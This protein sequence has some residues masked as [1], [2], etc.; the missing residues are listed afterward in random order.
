MSRGSKAKA[1]QRHARRRARERFGIEFTQQVE[2]DVVKRI[3]AGEATLARKQSNRVSVFFLDIQGQ[4]MAVVYDK[5]RK[6]VVTLFTAE[7][8]RANDF[9]DMKDSR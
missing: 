6:T 7:M 1:Q 2:E 5:Q 3:Q 8:E 4:E 9:T